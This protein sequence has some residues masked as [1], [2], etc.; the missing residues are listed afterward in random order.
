MIH[1]FRSDSWALCIQ[2]LLANHLTGLVSRHC[3]P[4]ARTRR[5]LLLRLQDLLQW[6]EL[7]LRA[8]QLG[9]G[10]LTGTV[11]AAVAVAVSN[12]VALAVAVVVVVVVV[13]A[14]TLL[15]EFERDGTPLGLPLPPRPDPRAPPA[16]QQRSAVCLP[17]LPAD[18]RQADLKAALRAQEQLHVLEEGI[19]VLLVPFQQLL[20]FRRE[21]RGHI[22]AGCGKRLVIRGRSTS[23]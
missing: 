23:R 17:D 16:P 19:G 9:S 12:A 11:A 6:N 4:A 20:P 22:S 15:L 10:R 3:C 1:G 21:M 8:I 5:P 13:S 18:G 7:L 14:A 2:T